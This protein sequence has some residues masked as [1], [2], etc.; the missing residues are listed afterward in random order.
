MSHRRRLLLIALVLGATVIYVLWRA[1]D[2]GARLVEHVLARYF[3]RPVLVEAITVRPRTLELEVHGL[4]VGGIS[5]D[6]PPFLEVPSARVRPSFAPLR[7]NRLVLSRVRVQGLRLRINAFPSPPLGPGG[8]DIPK[9]GGGRGGGLQVSIQRLVIVGGEFILDHRRVPLDVDLPDFHGRLVGRPEGGLAGHISFEPGRLRMGDAPELPV[10]TEIDVVVHRG[11]VDVQGARLVAEKTNLEYRGRIRLAG[12]PQGQLSLQGSVDL[13]VLDKHVFRSGLGLEGAAGWSGLL[14]I[15]GSRLRIEGRMAG[16]GG[17]FMGVAVPRFSG[18]LSYDGATGLV[19]RDLDVD[20]LG[21]QAW[22]AVDVPPK[23]TRRPVHIRGPLRE[24][25]GEGLLRMV[26]GWGE[27]GVGAAAT[28]DVDASW[29]RGKSRLVSGTIGV[30]LAERA[31]GR[32]PLAGRVDWRAEE[33]RQTYER[34]VL[35][36]PGTTASFAG[37]V[38]AEDRARLDVQADTK[39]LA[40]TETLL[41]RVRRALGNAE[42][43]PTGFKGS[44]SF[45]G[46]WRGTVDWPVFEGRFDG[47]GVAYSGVDWGRV[48]WAG[49]FDTAAESVESRPLVLRKGAG[50]IV[51]NGLTQIG[52]LGLRDAI[53]GRGRA[54]AWPVEDLVTFMEWDVV[55]TGLVSGEA[56]VRGR[57]SAPE[58]EA[59]GTARAGR[60]YAIPYDEAHVESRWKAGVAEVTRG[61]A[62]VGGGTLAF[63]GSVTDDGV[64]DGTA[65]MNG[66]D[67]G[68]LAPAPLP[69]APFGGRL[70]GRLAM[71]GTLIRPRL[72]AILSS[73]RLFLGD[74]GIGAL[75]ARLVGAGDGR[76]VIDGTCRSARLDVVLAGAVGAFP[77]YAADLTLEA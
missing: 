76:V 68:A 37:E 19:M 77:P 54:S 27:M 44:G 24:A 55:A 62:R 45:R 17:A 32:F 46:L 13:A 31:D 22:L 53:E 70:S 20:A 52:W 21:G 30:D 9:V 59:R 23:A 75:D 33:G 26:F 3:K 38:D 58:G 2:W 61:E 16:T 39:D 4:R 47:E 43:Q 35:R 51:W 10:G 56:S 66:V 12:R 36:G 6:A 63:R 72:R 1:P 28:G 65:E 64:Y 7:G 41:T 67:L 18:W 71:Q 8:D 57:R 60:F 25:D 74:E 14:S 11:V 34:V 50:E 40:A 5:P 73:P 42:A 69:A 48:Q 49:T 29:P 15:D